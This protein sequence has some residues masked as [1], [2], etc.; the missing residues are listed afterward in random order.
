MKHR[1]LIDGEVIAS[2]GF[3]VG[4]V[5]GSCSLGGVGAMGSKSLVSYFASLREAQLFLMALA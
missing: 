3:A 5:W 4:K 1:H 2:H